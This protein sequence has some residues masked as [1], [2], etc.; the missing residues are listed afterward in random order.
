M[1]RGRMEILCG[2]RAVSGATNLPR[3]LFRS[4][5]TIDRNVVRI[6]KAPAPCRQTSLKADMV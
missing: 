3:I 5:G 1:G 4:V 2:R 6:Q